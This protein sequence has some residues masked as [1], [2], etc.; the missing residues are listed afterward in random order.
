MKRHKIKVE[1]GA[2]AKIVFRGVIVEIKKINDD[3]VEII[4]PDGVRFEELANYL[5]KFNVIKPLPYAESE[6]TSGEDSNSQTKNDTA[7][8]QQDYAAINEQQENEQDY[9]AS[10]NDN[11]DMINEEVKDDGVSTENQ[12]QK[13]STTRKR[14]RQ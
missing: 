4:I 5:H 11:K 7:S 12:K 1:K 9:Q 8:N 6:A 3:E 14:K 2:N 13:S 10:T